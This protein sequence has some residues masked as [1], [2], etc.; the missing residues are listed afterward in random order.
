MIVGHPIHLEVV[1]KAI[2]ESKSL[3]YFKINE[4]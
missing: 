3:L 2:L 1:V 4:K